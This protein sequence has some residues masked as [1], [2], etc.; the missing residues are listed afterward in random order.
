MRHRKT[1]RKL[2]RDSAHRRALFRNMTASLLAHGRIE[3]T[4]AKAKELR[5]FVEPVI[6]RAVRIRRMLPKSARA[7]LTDEQRLRALHLRRLLAQRLPAAVTLREED[8]DRLL[9]RRELVTLLVEEI[10]PRYLDRPGGY[11][12]IRKLAFRRKGD[13][14]PLAVI[15][16]V[17]AEAPVEKAP[18]EET[19]GKKRRAGFFRRSKAEA[20]ADDEKRDK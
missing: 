11:T 20:A 14:A 17:P 10:A 6:T 8:G 7:K 3:T 13:N 15:E 12:R 16:L 9:S 5:G 4:Q 1:G 18:A 2:G 19:A